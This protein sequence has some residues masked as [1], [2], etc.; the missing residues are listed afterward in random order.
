LLNARN[1][2]EEYPVF[3]N[4]YCYQLIEIYWR[5][6][7]AFP[8]DNKLSIVRYRPYRKTSKGMPFW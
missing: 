3:L 5:V 6:C 7:C 2:I 4:L 1:E 8:V